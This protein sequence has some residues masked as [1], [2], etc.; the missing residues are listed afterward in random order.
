MVQAVAAAEQGS[1]CAAAE[2]F[3]FFSAAEQGSGCISSSARVRWFRLYI[4]R[5]K[6]HI[7]SPTEQGLHS[8][9]VQARIRLYL[10]R[11]KVWGVSPTEQGLRFY[12]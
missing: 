12:I 4:Q 1:D 8:I 11:S 10:Q 7:V 5:S 6:V 2:Q 3:S 9:S